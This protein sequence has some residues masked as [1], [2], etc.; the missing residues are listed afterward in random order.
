VH[1]SVEE[2]VDAIA[3]RITAL[4][5]IARGT[6]AA[7]AR[8]TCLA[9]YPEEISA[10]PAHVAALADRLADFGRRVRTDIAAATRL[11]D[12]GTAD[13]LTG[14]SRDVDKQL[15]FLEAHLHAATAK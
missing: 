5:G 13:L 14:I 1:G 2:H 12:A 10:G 9:P 8:A 11:D 6:V 7:V 15:W 3:E 4:G